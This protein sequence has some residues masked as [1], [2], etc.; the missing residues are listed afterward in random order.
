MQPSVATQ[1]SATRARGNK[2]ELLSLAA[3][4]ALVQ[5]DRAGA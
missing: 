4:P 5:Q 1:Y 2:K 3:S